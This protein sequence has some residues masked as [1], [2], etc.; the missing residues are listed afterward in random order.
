VA[1]EVV[2]RQALVVDLADYFGKQIEQST[3]QTTQ[4]LLVLVVLVV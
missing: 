4:L 1:V 2:L 3:L